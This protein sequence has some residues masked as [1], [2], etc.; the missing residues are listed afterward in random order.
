MSG[1]TRDGMAEPNSRDQ[2][3]RR[4]RGQ[5]KFHF[6]CSADHEQDWQPYPSLLGVLESYRGTGRVVSG[7]PRITRMNIIYS[8]RY[9]LFMKVHPFHE[10]TTF[11]FMKIKLKKK[12]P[13][14]FGEGWG[15]GRTHL[16]LAL[17]V[18]PLTTRP[19]RDGASFLLLIQTPSGGVFIDCFPLGFNM[20]WNAFCPHLK[21]FYLPPRPWA[22]RTETKHWLYY[23][24]TLRAV[25][26]QRWLVPYLVQN[27]PQILYPTKYVPYLWSHP[28]GT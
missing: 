27:A 15:G 24:L 11:L 10:G 22:S 3:L 1:L 21:G 9:T 18:W 20:M 7:L 4:E 14:R 19:L 26:E 13:G 25:T 17:V 23:Y 6:L 2:T 12:V 28:K 16:L 5:G 8:L